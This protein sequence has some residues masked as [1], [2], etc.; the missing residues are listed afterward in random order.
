MANVNGNKCID[1]KE[2]KTPCAD[3][4]DTKIEQK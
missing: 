3:C 2:Y 4:H 1:E